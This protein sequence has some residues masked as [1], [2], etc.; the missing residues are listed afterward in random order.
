VAGCLSAAAV[1][2]Q[3]PRL[4]LVPMGAAPHVGWCWLPGFACG[5][6]RLPS[7]A[8][9]Q[10]M[11]GGVCPVV[12]ECGV[13]DAS[14]LPVGNARRAGTKAAHTEHGENQT[15][16]HN[17]DTLLSTQGGRV[18][19]VSTGNNTD[20]TLLIRT[21][22]IGTRRFTGWAGGCLFLSVQPNQP[23]D[24]RPAIMPSF[25]LLS[26]MLPIPII[27]ANNVTIPK[28]FIVP[29]CATAALASVI[30]LLIS[31]WRCKSSS[32]F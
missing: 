7:R 15:E 16:P 23:L 3:N 24:F 28:G 18:G 31:S 27:A 21:A 12:P 1:R 29:D 5:A 6:V 9:V 11:A 2:Y 25:F 13:C 10:L 17:T 14:A 26:A 8:Y 32:L 30:A 4:S 22:S 19:T 20:N